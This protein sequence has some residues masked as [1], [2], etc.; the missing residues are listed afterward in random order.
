MGDRDPKSVIE[1]LFGRGLAGDDGVIDE[2]VA[3]DMVNHA[4]GGEDDLRGPQGRAAGNKSSRQSS[5]ISAET[6]LSIIA[7][8]SPKASSWPI[9]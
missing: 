3:E 7:T 6:S 9:T 8:S 1:E 4:A 5:T 2:L